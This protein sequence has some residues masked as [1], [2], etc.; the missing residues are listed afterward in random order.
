MIKLKTPHSSKVLI[1]DAIL[2]IIVIAIVVYLFEIRTV[3]S[4]PAA[5]IVQNAQSQT[6]TSV[7]SSTLPGQQQIQPLA[8]LYATTT[9]LQQLGL[10][11]RASLPAD[12][13]MLFIFA[14]PGNYGFWMK[15]MH[16]SIDM[17]WMDSNF[18]ITHIAP[19]VSPD[20]YP[21]SFYPNQ[22]S[23]YVLEANAG[24][25][26]NNNLS[27]GETLNFVKNSVQNMQ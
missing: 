26:Q 24:Y 27:V 2:A 13:G 23:S 17:I 12:E 14:T 19:D 25:S 21:A 20:T 8:L 7:S 11:N 10:G 5:P 16:F 22:N 4:A 18:V 1:I 3:N 15:D 6:I 9:A